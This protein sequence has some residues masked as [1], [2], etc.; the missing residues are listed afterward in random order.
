MG[1]TDASSAEH[2]FPGG[3]V[4]AHKLQHERISQRV[5]DLP[6]PEPTIRRTVYVP[7]YSNIYLGLD[8]RQ[9]VCT[10]QFP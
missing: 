6:L 3:V 10:A 4:V 8:I 2:L 1:F 9:K 7:V 5:E